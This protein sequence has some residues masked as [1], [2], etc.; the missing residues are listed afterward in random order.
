MAHLLGDL[1]GY[2]KFDEINIDN[3]T[4]KL[5]YKASMV[6]CMTGATV[7]IASQYFGDPI[8]CEFQGINSDLAQ[9]YCWI[10][11]SS[12]I[13]PEYQG[14]VKCIVDQEDIKSPHDAPDTSY[15]QWV[16]FVFA[17]Q[18]A[19]FYLPYKIWKSL[20][21]GLLESFGTDGKTP[22]MISENAKY[23][24][25]VVMEAVVEKFV[26]YYKAIFHHNSW[27]FACFVFCE[28]LNFGLLFLQFQLT[29]SFLNYKFRWY[30]W[31]VVKFYSFDFKTR[32][33][34][35]LNM[36]NPSCAVFP[37]IT[38]CNIPNVGAAGG[39]QF[40]NGL[41]VLT[42]NIINEKIFLVLWF[43][44]AF[45]GPVSVLFVFYRLITILF[46]GVRFTLIYKTVRH[47]YDDGIRR[48]LEF[49]L[50]KGQIGD[51][52]VLYQLSK[53]CSSY[54]FR[55]FI[56]ELAM[57]L[58][59]RPKSSKSKSS[60]LNSRSGSLKKKK[61]K[62][63]KDTLSKRAKD[64]EGSLIGMLDGDSVESGQV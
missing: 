38:S 5:F 24:D 32:N 53:N 35:E 63:L 6:I 29:D 44:Y 62:A 14:H 21:G 2:F 37:T 4:F 26:K 25:G 61:E 48:C 16:T 59:H 46:D 17:L 1:V 56:R 47:K 7:G 52:F 3:W 33:D 28:M 39:S 42:Q 8:S 20:E 18:A 12:Y 30:G 11:G 19:I 64:Q 45:L 23:D 41:C 34:P 49:I 10:T 15:Y 58:K 36:R 50:A 40:H 31:D 54:F 13:P 9:D 57:E 43:W 55:E 22:V 60:T 51:W 27:Y